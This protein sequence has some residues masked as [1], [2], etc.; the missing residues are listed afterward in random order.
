M[1]YILE[2]NCVNYTNTLGLFEQFQSFMDGVLNKF[3]IN[4]LEYF[5][6]ASIDPDSLKKSIQKHANFINVEISLEG[7]DS[8]FLAG[9][10]ISNNDTG[11]QAVIIHQGVLNCFILDLQNLKT[12]CFSIGRRRDSMLGKKLLATVMAGLLGLFLGA[13]AM[14]KAPAEPGPTRYIA[15]P[16]ADVLSP[17]NG[18]LSA[19]AFL[20]APGVATPLTFGGIANNLSLRSQTGFANNFQVDTGIVANRMLPY[21]GQLNLAGKWGFIQ[22]SGGALASV[23]ALAGGILAVD[24][25]GNPTLGFQVGLPISK[26]FAFNGINTL[27]VSLYPAYNIGL[28][29]AAQLLP[30]GAVPTAANYLS[31]GMGADFA[32]T[33]ALH[34]M[35]DNN[36]GLLG[37]AGAISR[38]NVGVRYALTPNLMAD[39]FLGFSPVGITNVNAAPATLG[40]AAHWGF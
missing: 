23:A 27:G 37:V 9:K 18:I 34:L 14:A 30:G 25:N 26:V 3:G 33:P 7:Y 15:V 32:I 24:L 28:F 39:V 6:V 20:A 36:F 10:T 4:S 22:Q 1:N 17:G 11:E 19:G 5:V 21:S 12:P 29:P 38:A 8:Y 40:V 13:P 31:L 16:R 35:A 2:K